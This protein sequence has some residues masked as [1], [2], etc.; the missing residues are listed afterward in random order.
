MASLSCPTV[1]LAKIATWVFASLMLL[2]DEVFCQSTTPEMMLT[3]DS[4]SGA[5]VTS[6]RYLSQDERAAL[7]AC[8]LGGLMAII[9]FGFLYYEYKLK[10]YDQPYPYPR[11][12]KNKKPREVEDAPL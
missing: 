3:V 12:K 2:Q 6:V 4:G 7:W 11:K 10:K 5:Q 9:G 8:F 1:I